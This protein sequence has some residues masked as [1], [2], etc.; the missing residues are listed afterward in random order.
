MNAKK[1]QM[2]ANLV[3]MRDFQKILPSPDFWMVMYCM[4]LSEE[5]VVYA[6]LW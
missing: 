4:S 2:N 3:S 6:N 1:N 5:N